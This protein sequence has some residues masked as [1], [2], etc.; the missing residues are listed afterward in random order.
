MAKGCGARQDG[1]C[2]GDARFDLAAVHRRPRVAQQPG[3]APLPVLSL[4]SSRQT[5]LLLHCVSC[6][7]R[8][9]RC[10]RIVLQKRTHT[11]RL[12]CATCATWYG[13]E[14]VITRCRICAECPIQL[15]SIESGFC[16]SMPP[17]TVQS[18]S[19]AEALDEN[20]AQRSPVQQEV[21]VEPAAIPS[22]S[23]RKVRW[24]KGCHRACRLSFT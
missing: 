12:L 8:Q 6:T 15:G 16:L 23:V 5:L 4:Q 17:V 14:S 22:R 18:R 21:A 24:Q 1:C 13:C 11:S 2:N 3:A 10:L 9:R 7:S 20:S 19:L